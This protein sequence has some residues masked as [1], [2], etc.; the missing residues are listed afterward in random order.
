MSNIIEIEELSAGNSVELVATF[1]ILLPLEDFNQEVEGSAL[2]TVASLLVACYA[3]N[4][5][6][7]H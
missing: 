1:F 4:A 6:L 7:N 2:Y 5:E 3:V